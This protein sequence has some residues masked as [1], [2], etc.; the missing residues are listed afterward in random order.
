MFQILG[1]TGR[2][3]ML[4][5]QLRASFQQRDTRVNPKSSHG[6]RGRAANWLSSPIA[7]AFWLALIDGWATR[8]RNHQPVALPTPPR[9]RPCAEVTAQ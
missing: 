2:C 5:K 9:G 6:E 4:R 3:Q 1:M 8:L 7:I